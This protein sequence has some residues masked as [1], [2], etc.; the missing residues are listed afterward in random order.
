[1]FA[2]FGCQW[3]CHHRDRQQPQLG[4]PREDFMGVSALERAEG[5]QD[6]GKL[7]ALFCIVSFLPATLSHLGLTSLWVLQAFHGC[8]E[9]HPTKELRREQFCTVSCTNYLPVQQL[10]TACIC[11]FTCLCRTC[12]FPPA[13][14]FTLSPSSHTVIGGF[15]HLPTAVNRVQ[16]RLSRTCQ[17]KPDLEEEMQA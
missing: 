6:P 13:G 9:N 17:P 15:S 16:G 12:R 5:L 2:P 7:G 14:D 4:R 3:L 8:R 10:D 11:Y 1:M